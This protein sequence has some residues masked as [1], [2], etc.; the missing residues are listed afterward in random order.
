MSLIKQHLY[1]QQRNQMSAVIEQTKVD[2]LVDALIEQLNDKWKVNAIE[3]GHPSYHFLTREEGKRYI[4]L[5]DNNSN[6]SGR[7]VYMFV[8]KNDGAVY[9][10]ASWKAPAKG[11]R[12]YIEQL[13]EY[14]D[15]CDPYGSF[16]YVA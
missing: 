6:S 10:S 15:I 3:S 7:S 14:P 11:I 2:F 4:K 12:F 13:T 8:D 9:K 16:L 1:Q 5:I